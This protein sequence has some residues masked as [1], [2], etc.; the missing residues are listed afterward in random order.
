LRPDYRPPE[1]QREGL[2][3]FGMNGWKINVIHYL[4]TEAAWEETTRSA[5]SH[6]HGE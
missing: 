1:A 3:S 4:K 6:E 5:L 2:D